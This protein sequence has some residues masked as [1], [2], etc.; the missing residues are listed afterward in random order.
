MPK[1]NLNWIIW[2]LFFAIG[3]AIGGKIGSDRAEKRAEYI[4]QIA[5]EQSIYGKMARTELKYFSPMKY[6]AYGV[7]IGG[8]SGLVLY[9]ALRE[10]RSRG[11]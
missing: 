11:G 3:A 5:Q 9:G 8:I 1:L 7:S 4:K 6:I 2:A 10:H